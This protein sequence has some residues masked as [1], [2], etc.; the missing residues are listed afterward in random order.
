MSIAIDRIQKAYDLL[1]TYNGANPY[2]V[3]LKNSVF[4]YKDKQ[5]TDFECNYVIENHDFEPI[6]VNKIVKVADWWGEKMKEEWKIEFVPKKVK[7]TWLLGRMDGLYHFFCIYRKSQEKAVEV[8]ATDRAILTDFLAEDYRLKNIDFKPYN[9]RS[10]REL[11]PH[12]EEAIK[13]LTTRKKA[14]LA[15]VMGVGKSVSAIVSALED[16]YEHVLIICP[17]SLK[18]NWQKELSLY[19]DEDDITI[20]EGSKW[21]DNRFTIINYDILK[22]FYEVPTVMKKTKELNLTDEGEIVNVVKEKEVVSRSRSVIEKAMENSQLYQSRF[23]LIIIDEAHR[24]SNTSSGI[25]KIV[26]DL[27]ERSRPKGIYELSGTLVT[28]RPMNLYNMLKII[29]HPLSKDWKYYVNRYCDGK[30]FFNKNEKKAYTAIFLKNRKKQSWYDLTD[31]EREELDEY[32]E[33]HCKKVWVTTGASHLDDLQEVIKTCYMRRDKKDLEL[34]GKTVRTVEYDLSD[35]E[36]KE[37][38]N[39]WEQYLNEQAEREKAEKHKSITEGIVFRQWLADT[40]IPRTIKLVEKLTGEGKK[41]IVFCS[42]DNEI[43]QLKEHFGDSAV[44]HNGKQTAKKKDKAVDAFQNDPNVKVFIGNI[45]SAG[46]G[47]T[48]IASST[49]VFNSI[50]FVPGDMLQA[51]DRIHRLNQTHDCTI[52]YQLFK[53]TYMEHM[54]DIVHGKNEIINQIII[55]ETEK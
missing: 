31:E 17:A 41:V 5:L 10:G 33:Q 8:F 25:Y 40:M 39:V 20:V 38:D 18:S 12:Q 13:F 2:I 28:N 16:K 53:D 42:F 52:Y 7:I 1:K 32:L 9:E 48:L 36:R 47:L 43:K 55:R 27:V 30:T 4:A 51:E 24:L 35:S 15:D 50:T 44:I 37:Y 34:V 46:V 45:I 54:F 6:R 3:K 11:Y 14:I 22:N 49:V 29:G 23:D 21:K 19:V 26:S